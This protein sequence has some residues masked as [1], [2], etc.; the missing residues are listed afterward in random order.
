MT[1]TPE[2]YESEIRYLREMCLRMNQRLQALTNTPETHTG[3]GLHND[4]T[5]DTAAR[6]ADRQR[7]TR[8]RTN[9]L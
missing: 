6:N 2:S 7:Q 8:N 1:R 5:G 4:R 9:G 3:R